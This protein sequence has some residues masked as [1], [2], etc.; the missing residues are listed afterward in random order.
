MKAKALVA[1]VALV[2]LA[3]SPAL[4]APKDATLVMAFKADAPTMDPHTDSSQLTYQF[5][6]WVFQ[7]LM[8]RTPEGKLI[9]YLAKSARWVD[10]KTLEFDIRPGVKFSNGEEADAEAVKYSLRRIFDPKLK[11][12]QIDRM[13]AIRD[14]DSVEVVS[15]YRVRLHL[16][17]SDGGFLNRLANSGLIVPPKYYSGRDPKYLATRPIG[18]G[19]YL[20]K[21]WVRDDHAL[22]EANPTFYDSEY[23]KVKKVLAKIIP[24]ENARVAALMKGEVD[25]I[26]DV[27]PPMFDRINQ[28]GKARLVS[29]PGIRIFR[30]GFFNKWGGI[31]A[32]K[33]IREAVARS[34]DRATLQKSVMKG[35]AVDVTQ[36]FH[37]LIM[38]GYLSPEE[39]PYPYG[40]DPEKARKLLAEAGHPNGLDIELIAETGGYMKAKEVAEVVAGMLQ[41]A[42]IRVKLS[43]L[44]SFA[45]RNR[46]LKHRAKAGPDYA[47]FL[48]FHSFGGGNGDP[49]VQVSALFG[50][51]GAWSG[52]CDKAIDQLADQAASQTD[53]AKRHETFATIARKGSKDVI[54]VPLYRLNATFG[55]SSRV[56]WDPRVDERAMGWEIGLK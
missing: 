34:I 36:I 7:P 35:A 23:P 29:K 8:H 17:Y 2:G 19:P 3:A 27:P 22:Y 10:S 12:R 39:Y 15:K 52:W 26:F 21:E 33:R 38:N 56:D 43:A 51:K 6:R 14:K 49:D 25:V 42:G 20:L 5:A 53:T 47:P 46:F 24:E 31:L 11:S 9:P 1:A 50:C 45:F 55:L 54:V 28:S 4:A 16:P 32:D 37:P 40:Y 48:F 30:L 13:R 41:K 18:S 44:G